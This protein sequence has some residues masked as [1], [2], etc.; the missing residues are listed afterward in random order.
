MGE[1][2]LHDLKPYI[3]KYGC[4]VFVETGTG[5]GTGIQ[6]ALRYDFKKLYTIEIMEE[7]WKH[8]K[9]EIKDPRVDFIHNNSLDGMKGILEEVKDEECVFFWLDAHFPGADFHFNDYEHLKDQP[10]LHKPL[11]DEV[12]MIKEARPNAKDVFIIDD[13]QIYEDGPF[14]LL[15]QPFKDK[16]GELGIEFVTD[17]YEESHD[18]KRD[19]RH[20]GFLILTPKD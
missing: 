17:S 3:D 14:E 2:Y 13:L 1:L 4:N 16:Y 12:L 19:Y 18:M 11:K 20:Q 10:K 7:L 15:N 9:K 6:H 5:V 8:C